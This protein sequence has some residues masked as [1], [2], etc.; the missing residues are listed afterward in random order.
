MY[1]REPAHLGNVPERYD[2]MLLL[3]R[4]FVLPL[5]AGVALC[6]GAYHE[7]HG[8]PGAGTGNAEKQL[9]KSTPAQPSYSTRRCPLHLDRRT[10]GLAAGPAGTHRFT[11]APL[12]RPQPYLIGRRRLRLCAARRR[13]NER[14]HGERCAFR[15]VPSPP[16][17]RVAGAGFDRL[18][19]AVATGAMPEWP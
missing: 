2:R 13:N 15:H 17:A 14:W 5:A 18:A 6:D 16:A 10:H 9:V 1:F 12:A 11:Y 3:E 7:R 4:F 8:R 19:V